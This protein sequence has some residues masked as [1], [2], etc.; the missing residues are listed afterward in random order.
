MLVLMPGPE[1][2]SAVTGSLARISGRGGL[3]T[4]LQEAPSRRARLPKVPR[5]RSR[6]VTIRLVPQATAAVGRCHTLHGSSR[7]QGYVAH[8]CRTCA[9]GSDQPLALRVH[10]GAPARRQVDDSLRAKAERVR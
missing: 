6:R 5:W 3:S 8:E 4:A 7:E 1:P 2:P 9:V 10:P